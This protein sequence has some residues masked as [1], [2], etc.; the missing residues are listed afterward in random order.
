MNIK[1]KSRSYLAL[2]LLALSVGGSSWA[3][4]RTVSAPLGV[5]AFA[6]AA[7]QKTWERTDR[8]VSFGQVQRSFYWGP[9]P[10][11]GGLLEDYAEGIGGKRL[12]QYFDKS[13]MEIND[14]NADPNN[15]FFV[16]NGLLTVELISGRMQVGNQA[17]ETRTPADIPLASDT[18]DPNAPTYHSF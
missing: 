5:P 11:T 18:D 4:A 7:F 6:H 10:N 16:T 17:Y 8:P 3:V 9:N 1:R 12:V 2:P 13:R 15:P 14:P